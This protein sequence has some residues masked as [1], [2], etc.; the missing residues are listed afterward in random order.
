LLLVGMRPL[1]AQDQSQDQTDPY[2]PY[3]SSGPEADQSQPPESNR[4]A[5]AV[6]RLSFV[7]GDVSTQRGDNGNWEAV[8]LNTPIAVG[9]RVSTGSGGRAE[10]QLDYANALRL[11]D[12]ATAKI[13]ALS[14]ENIQVQVGQGLTTYSVLRGGEASAEIDTPNAAIHPNGPGNYRIS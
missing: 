5:P 4:A 10:I 11:S 13:A 1:V 3:S 2:A 8:T 14:R 7:H 12:G 9:D 6:A